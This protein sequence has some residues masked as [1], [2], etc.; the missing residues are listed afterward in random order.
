MD[1]F[2]G[3]VRSIAPFIGMMILVGCG[4]SSSDTSYA[5]TMPCLGSA[6]TLS[7]GTISSATGG[8]VDANLN[9]QGDLTKIDTVAVSLVAPGGT[10]M[11]LAVLSS[12]IV[13]N[14]TVSMTVNSGTGVGDYFLR[15]TF[16]A[17]SPSNTGS[18][19]YRNTSITSSSYTY[20]EWVEGVTT[21]NMSTSFAIPKLEVVP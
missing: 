10:S 6:P 1:L 16:R 14:N 2:N 3:F 15:V 7:T 20:Y 18:M 8:T 17:V 5:C 13:A 12:P 19:Y 4:G 21:S 9:L 11:G